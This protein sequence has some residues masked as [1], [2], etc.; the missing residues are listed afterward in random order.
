MMSPLEAMRLMIE[1]D[2]LVVKSERLLAQEPLD[3][4][5]LIA[6][7]ERMAEIRKQMAEYK[8]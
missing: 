5:A 3:K 4:V 8:P 7:R 1:A 2:A 6:L